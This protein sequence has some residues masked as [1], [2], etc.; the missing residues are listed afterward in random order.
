MDVGDC[1]KVGKKKGAMECPNGGTHNS[2]YN[3]VILEKRERSRAVGSYADVTRE[4]VKT[5]LG[6]NRLI[7]S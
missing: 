7:I 4:Y 5:P 1:G 3:V 2:T 6:Q